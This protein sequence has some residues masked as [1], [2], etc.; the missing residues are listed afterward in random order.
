MRY[1]GGAPPR[2]PHH[3]SCERA[4][5]GLIPF[6]GHTPTPLHTTASDRTST[7]VRPRTART[8]VG[9]QG[10]ARRRSHAVDATPGGT[11]IDHLARPCARTDRSCG[12]SPPPRRSPEGVV[13]CHD[14]RTSNPTLV[15][16]RPRSRAAGALSAPPLPESPI[17]RD[18]AAPRIPRHPF[19]A[20]RPAA[21]LTAD[22]L[23]RGSGPAPSAR[24]R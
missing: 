12:L 20:C 3:P 9:W 8:R 24:G 4:R 13:R 5:R 1:P 7:P 23:L 16:L 14:L 2:R 6:L 17:S 11:P 15:L 21:R 22:R 18:P 19:A 10:M